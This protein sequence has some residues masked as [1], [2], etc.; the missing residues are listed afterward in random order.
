ML[1]ISTYELMVAAIYQQVL[2]LRIDLTTGKLY[3]IRAA[4]WFRSSAIPRQLQKGSP[5]LL[6]S[7]KKSFLKVQESLMGS[8]CTTTV[9]GFSNL[10]NVLL[11]TQTA[12]TQANQ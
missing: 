6:G 9:L 12:K 8:L 2:A 11:S 10:S 3:R 5:T 4:A 1:G 7:F